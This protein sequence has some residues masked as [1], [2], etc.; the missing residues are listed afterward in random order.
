MHTTTIDHYTKS[1]AKPGKVKNGDHSKIVETPDYF[2]G[3]ISDGISSFPCDHEASKLC[4]LHLT[5]YVEQHY[6]ETT[7]LKKLVHDALDFT[8]QNLLK[9]ADPCDG[10]GCTVCG[11][12]WS[13]TTNEVWCFWVGDSR[14]Y[15]VDQHNKLLQWSKDDSEEKIIKGSVSS[16]QSVESKSYL[17]NFLGWKNC[18]FWIDAVCIS[19]SDAPLASFVLATDGFFESVRDF[20]KTVLELVHE[21]DFSEAFEK[22]FKDT[23]P[24]QQDDS[25]VLVLRFIPA[26]DE[27]E[28]EAFFNA[29]TGRD[30]EIKY[31]LPESKFHL[32]RLLSVAL[33]RSI[34]KNDEA[35]CISLLE[36]IE[37]YRIKLTKKEL[38]AL[39]EQL[40]KENVNPAGVYQKLVLML[41]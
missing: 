17:T 22:V 3:V 34:T 11:V 31:T 30:K 20:D 15:T 7:D 19:N 14:I 16:G 1:L 5:E 37:K 10:L 26:L 40:V 6:V 28:I 33:S 29:L 24:Y 39:L 12:L 18:T 4:C 21:M 23:I 13:K 2:L 25:T 41:R 32:T 38:E 35:S 9:V 8:N 27:A 36:L